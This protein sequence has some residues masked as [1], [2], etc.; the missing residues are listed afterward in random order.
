MAGASFISYR[1]PPKAGTVR[2]FRG[3]LNDYRMCEGDSL[4]WLHC[5]PA[6]GEKSHK[7]TECGLPIEPKEEYYEVVRGGGGLG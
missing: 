4:S 7:C 2:T 5:R 1:S 3:G 6:N